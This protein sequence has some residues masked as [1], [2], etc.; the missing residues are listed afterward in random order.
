[1]GNK[2]EKIYVH[3]RSQQVNNLSSI[4]NWWTKQMAN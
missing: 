3:G 4:F 2:R 1:V